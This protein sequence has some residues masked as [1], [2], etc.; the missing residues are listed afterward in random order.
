VLGL[1]QGPQEG[2]LMKRVLPL[3]EVETSIGRWVNI[4][5]QITISGRKMRVVGIDPPNNRLTVED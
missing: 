4:N 5:D 2:G 1:P 3:K